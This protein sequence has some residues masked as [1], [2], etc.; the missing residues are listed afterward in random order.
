MR[1]P[2]GSKRVINL[3]PIGRRQQRNVQR[4]KR[5]PSFPADYVQLHIT[6][7]A[8]LVSITYTCNRLRR[9]IQPASVTRAYIYTIF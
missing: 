8:Q 5:L 6:S 2:C 4:A 1:F 3:V 7:L 9:E